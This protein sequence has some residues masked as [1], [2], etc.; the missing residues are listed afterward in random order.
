MRMQKVCLMLL[1]A[2]IFLG[3]CDNRPPPSDFVE[4]MRLQ[5]GVWP[6]SCPESGTHLLLKGDELDIEE[7]ETI[8]KLPAQWRMEFRRGGFERLRAPINAKFD[9][10]GAPLPEEDGTGSAAEPTPVPGSNPSPIEEC[11]DSEVDVY[12]H[13]VGIHT[14]GTG[15]TLQRYCVKVFLQIPDDN[16]TSTDK[17]IV[18][19]VQLEGGTIEGGSAHGGPRQK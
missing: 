10:S 16:D 17:L 18:R 5:D 7:T 19:A 9:C 12:E 3:G 11:A 6:L 4:R 1:A 15:E 14:R 2:A 8:V 13:L